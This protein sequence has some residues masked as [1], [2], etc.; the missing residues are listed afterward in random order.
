MNIVG[1][2]TVVCLTGNVTILVRCVQDRVGIGRCPKHSAN[3][4]TCCELLLFLLR[5]IKR[6][7]YAVC[8]KFKCLHLVFSFFS[9]FRVNLFPACRVALVA[10]Q[11]EA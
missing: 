4:S 8:N 7:T 6:N 1:H 3:T 2:W 5:P 11:R 9:T 10:E